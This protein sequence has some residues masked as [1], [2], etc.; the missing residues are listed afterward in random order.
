M[1]ITIAKPENDYA[2]LDSGE[3]EKLERFGKVIV[4]RP[5]PQALW[6]KTLSSSEWKKAQAYFSGQSEKSGG[7]QTKVDLPKKWAIEYG[8]LNFWI[9][10][11]TFKH[12]GIFPENEPTWMWMRQ[13]IAKAKRPVSVLNL[14]GY[15]GGSTLA[16]AQAGASVC[17]LDGSKVAVHWARENAELSGLH[18]K[19]IRWIID[20]ARSFVGRELKRAR[21]YDAIILDPP[22]FGHGPDGELWRIEKDLL[23]L[24]ENCKNILSSNPLFFLINGY[25]AGYSSIAYANNFRHLFGNKGNLETGE[26]TIAHQKNERLLPCGIFARW[27]A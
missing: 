17:H 3:S 15:T 4:C 5:D 20:D 25:A 14:F 11:S 18:E 13:Q 23:P 6:L 1:I 24:L 12:V 19:P 16:C 21:Q 27:S 2:L 26:L 9:K 7:W 8:G 22:A 10:L